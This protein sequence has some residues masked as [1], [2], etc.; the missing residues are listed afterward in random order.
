MAKSTTNDVREHG[1]GGLNVTGCRLEGPDGDGHW[2]RGDGSDKTS[3]P[4]FE[5]G[6]TTGGTKNNLGR[7]PPNV[8]VDENVAELIDELVGKRPSGA[9]PSR[10]IAT[11]FQLTYGAMDGAM[12]CTPARGAEVG[13]ASRFFYCPK[14]TTQEREA[15]CES[16]PLF[17]AGELTGGR[18]EGSAALDCP[19][20]GAGR[21]LKGRRNHHP[22]VKPI[23]LTRWLVRLVMPPG[24]RVLDPFAGSGT[25]AIACLYEGADFVGVERESDYV[26]IHKARVK[27]WACPWRIAK[28]GQFSAIFKI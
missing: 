2:S 4:G 19:R 7:W 17:T 23:E 9:N 12:D 6:F 21:T 1:I 24:G 11:K 10:R 27:Y 20:T 26:R 22:T 14:T 8:A 5:G 3:T 18:K 13:G 25:T 16:L 28:T 15:G